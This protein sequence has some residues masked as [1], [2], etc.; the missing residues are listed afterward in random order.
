[1]EL[2]GSPNNTSLRSFLERSG[3]NDNF[4]F[5]RI[6]KEDV[7]SSI[8]TVL[9][10]HKLTGEKIILTLKKKGFAPQYGNAIFENKTLLS[11]S[12]IQENDKYLQ[13]TAEVKDELLVTATYPA[14]Q[15]DI[16][17]EVASPKHVIRETAKNYNS[18]TKPYI[19]NLPLK[20]ISW[21]YNILDD[22][23]NEETIHF[24]DLHP[25]NGLLIF[26]GYRWDRQTKEALELLVI[27]ARK[28]IR[29]LRDLRG[30]HIPLLQ[31]IKARAKA[32]ALNM[33]GVPANKLRGYVHYYPSFFHFH[34]HFYHVNLESN[35]VL[36][37]D[38]IE[39]LKID[40]DYYT[41]VT[42]NIVLEENHP[43][44]PQF[45]QEFEGTD[46]NNSSNCL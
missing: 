15:E 4:Q 38:I 45:S 14:T 35:K 42:L 27:I 34:V 33:Y 46:N 28:D 29:S 41:K 16:D 21:I 9:G 6:L 26:P 37:D 40:C 3:I 5:E 12:I 20:K 31:D 7:R 18:I 10:S 1:M 32:V 17:K 30:H 19:D 43:L 36:L 39:N 44:F 11:T 2:A 22:K 25:E 8:M 23:P 13:F 24:K